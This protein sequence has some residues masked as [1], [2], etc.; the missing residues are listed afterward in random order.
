MLGTNTWT[1]IMKTT[2]LYEPTCPQTDSYKRSSAV[3]QNYLLCT[4]K[5]FHI[6]FE[7]IT[8]YVT[9][10]TLWPTR[11]LPIARRAIHLFSHVPELA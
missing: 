11:Y 2:W 7:C 4:K 5:T 9:S 8:C 1:A 6:K 3:L 10:L